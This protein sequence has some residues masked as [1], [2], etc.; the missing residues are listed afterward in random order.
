MNEEQYREWEARHRQEERQEEWER[1]AQHHFRVILFYVF[2][3]VILSLCVIGLAMV[4][5]Y[6]LELR[7]LKQATERP[8]AMPSP[9]RANGPVPNEAQSETLSKEQ[10]AVLVKNFLM[11]QSKDRETEQKS[12]AVPLKE[13]LNFFDSLLGSGSLAN[14]VKEAVSDTRKKLFDAGIAV[15]TDV[16]KQI[17][18]KL[19]E[20]KEKPAAKDSKEFLGNL[21]VNVACAATPAPTPPK[22]PVPQ[23]PKPLP[24]KPQPPKA[25]C[26]AE[27]C[28]TCS[29][30]AAL[31]D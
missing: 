25:Q 13:V 27:P 11:A 20:T 17:T 28:P 24:P 21:N 23:P 5:K 3:F 29:S 30:T 14:E 10:T 12:S 8:M 7:R 26:K 4:M 18:A 16:I 22:P 1:R 2:T 19:L 9:A 15:T 31:P 6:D